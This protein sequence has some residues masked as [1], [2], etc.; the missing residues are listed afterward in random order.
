MPIGIPLFL[1]ILV[2]LE[3]YWAYSFFTSGLFDHYGYTFENLSTAQWTV[4]F[5]VFLMLFI[6]LIVIIYGFLKRKMW[7]RKFTILI[8]LIA[9]LL[10]L[11]GLAVEISVSEQ[12]ILIIIYL[13]LILYLM[14]T[15]VKNYFKE[16]TALVF[17]VDEEVYHHGK[18][19]LYTRKVTLKG[20]RTVTIYFFS[21]KKPKSGKP[22]S[23]PEGYEVGINTR[24]NMPYLKKKKKQK[25]KKTSKVTAVDEKKKKKPSNVIYVVNK[26][27]PGEVRGD[28][29]VRGHGKIYSH[30]KTKETAV[31]KA[32]TIAKQK[33]ATVMIQKTDGTFSKG[34]HP[35]KK[36]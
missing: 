34:F 27:Q 2:I 1:L 24:S 20:G 30:H 3:I 6:A 7:T 33:D 17:S 23:M 5:Y 16:I 25:I 4:L 10:P 26:P 9:L 12:L 14:T 18:Y 13:L 32:R 31:K 11:W 36:K 19:T 15:N 21:G 29:A 35:K 22:C 8:L 28:W